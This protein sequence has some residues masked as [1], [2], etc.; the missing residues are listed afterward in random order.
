[1]PPNSELVTTRRRTFPWRQAVRLVTAAVL[2]TAWAAAAGAAIS[3]GPYLQ[4]M[5]TTA[6][7]IQYEATD[8]GAGQVQFGTGATLDQKADFELVQKIDAS[9][10]PAKGAIAP[11]VA[12]ASMVYLYRAHLAGLK[13]ATQYAYQI[14]RGTQTSKPQT[15]R[16][17]PEKPAPITFIAYGDTRSNP[18]AHRDVVSGFAAH[19]PLF[20]L[21]DGDLASDGEDYSTWGPEFFG[22]LAD[23]IDR[24]PLFPSRG[25][26][27]GAGKNFQAFFEMPG[28]K[29]YFSFDCGPVHVAMLD[30]YDKGQ[31][32]IDWL[33]KDLAASKAPWKIVMYHEPTFNFAGHKS[34]AGRATILPVLERQGVD[35]VLAGH[36]HLYERFKP[37]TP[38]PAADGAPRHPVT[39]ITT[40]GGGA[41]LVKAV[42]HPLIVKTASTFHY[43]VF[44]VDA[45]TLKVQVLLPDGKPLDA[46]SITKKDGQ[47][48]KAYMADAVPMEEALKA[49]AK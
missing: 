26:H 38:A 39:F 25:N 11:A 31:A 16:T 18:K 10:K 36:S 24:I 41:P 43:C 2:V 17:F 47:Y 27:E 14:S 9:A 20:I 15:F 34:E 4:N 6:V 32:Q 3:K 44:T 33:D 5:G 49:K 22:P 30:N 8:E 46:F 40:G 45:E 28:G 42:E 19:K 29:D 48:D 21:H 13:P 1:M 12:G 7:T 37:M 23:V 35:I